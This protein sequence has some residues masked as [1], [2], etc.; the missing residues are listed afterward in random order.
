M[1]KQYIEYDN[2]RKLLKLDKEMA[3]YTSETI[4][5]IN[6][7]DMVNKEKILNSARGKRANHT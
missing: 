5:A 4:I 2:R 6:M 7:L 1:Y 3:I